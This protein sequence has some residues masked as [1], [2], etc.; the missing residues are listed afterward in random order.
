MKRIFALSLC[1]L[2]AFT[3]LAFAASAVKPVYTDITARAAEDSGKLVLRMA[4]NLPDKTNMDVGIWRLQPDRKFLYS[5]VPLAYPSEIDT[6]VSGGVLTVWFPSVYEKGLAAGTYQVVVS[7]MQA[8]PD[9]TLG[10]NN[11]RLAGD[12]VTTEAS[13]VKI[14]RFAF[15]ITTSTPLPPHPKKEWEEP[16]KSWPGAVKK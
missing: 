8:Q 15:D 11:G 14:H 4:T 13:G 7:V 9:N 2:L 3:A 12:G 6:V 1:L 10:E 5:G 16:A